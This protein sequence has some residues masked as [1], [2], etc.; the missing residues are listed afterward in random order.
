LFIVRYL[1]VFNHPQLGSLELTFAEEQP[2]ANRTEPYTSVVIGPNGTGK[3]YV[4]RTI[5][6]ILR[7]FK[8]YSE[9]DEKK[10]NLPYDIHFRYQFYHNTYEIVTKQLQSSNRISRKRY[11]F[12]KNRPIDTPYFDDETQQEIVTNF[13]VLYRELEFPEKLLVNSIIPTDRFV[14][15][16]SKP[17]DFYQYLGTRSTRST[18]STRSTSRRTVKH[19]FNASIL[20]QDF[21][22]R[23]KDLLSFLGFEHSFKVEYMTRANKLFFSGELTEENFRKFFE[24]WWDENFKFTTRKKENPL[25]SIPYYNNH[26][27]GRDSALA[28]I[29]IYLNNLSKGDGRLLPKKNSSAK[30]LSVDLFAGDISDDELTMI[31]HLE[32]LDIIALDGIK[33]NKVGSRLSIDQISSGEYHLLVSMIGIFST[34]SKDSLVLIDEPEISLHPNW[35][36]RYVSFLK[37]AFHRFSSCHFILTT[38]S[39]FLISDLE[40]ASSTVI[41]LARNEETGTIKSTTLSGVNTYSWSAEDVLYNVFNV[42]S[43]WNYFLEADL[44]ELLGMI[45]N[46]MTNKE[47][48]SAIINKLDGLPKRPNDPLQD[49]LEEA[50]YY[51]ANLA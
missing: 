5:A 36:M 23:L 24:E 4:L 20:D 16:E 46:N 50:K 7:Q 39:H 40:G 3:S 44:T 22:N 14:W 2:K 35:Q 49:I 13:E 47:R 17:G 42:R 21:K 26:F 15:Q 29:V 8:N 18:T 19:L 27:K 34:L 10:F 6:E 38:H 51:L 12:Y 30:I 25:W 9:T 33:I 28:K 1:K 31:G 37:S 11:L 48:I 41:S 32:N 45:S 43:T